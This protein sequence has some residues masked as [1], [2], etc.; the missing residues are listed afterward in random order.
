MLLVMLIDIALL[1]SKAD[2]QLLEISF[3]ALWSA[4]LPVL[5]L[6]V[7]CIALYGAETWTL[8][9]T[10]QKCLE[11]FEMEMDGGDQW[12]RSCER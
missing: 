7:R 6:V 9:K 8:R 1:R 11:N 10:D 3:I 5:C 2:K 12:D 4:P